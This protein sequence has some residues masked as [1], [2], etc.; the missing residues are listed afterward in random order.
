MRARGE[1]ASDRHDEAMLILR[2]TRMT[3]LLAGPPAPA[4]ARWRLIFPPIPYL[5]MSKANSRQYRLA[6]LERRSY[7]PRRRRTMK[8]TAICAWVKPISRRQESHDEAKGD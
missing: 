4:R 8:N 3:I 1:V 7:Y 6:P 5:E 2:M